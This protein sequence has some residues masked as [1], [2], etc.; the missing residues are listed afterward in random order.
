MPQY[1]MSMTMSCSRGFTTFKRIRTQR[2][3]GARCSIS[4]ALA[5]DFSPFNEIEL[6]QTIDE[7][8]RS[9]RFDDHGEFASRRLS[10]SLR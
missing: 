3:L 9:R 7:D 4:L 5:H 2:S 10:L 1:L 8:L 6:L